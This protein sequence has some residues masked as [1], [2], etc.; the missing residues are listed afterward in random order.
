[1][2]QIKL[3]RFLFFIPAFLVFIAAHA[4]PPKGIKWL[5]DGSGYYANESGEIVKY[6]LP[7]FSKTVLVDRKSLIPEGKTNALGVRNFFMSDDGKTVLLYNNTKKVWR[8]DTRGDYWVLNIETKSLKQ[9]GKS[10]PASSLMF[11]KLSPDGKYA[12]YVSGHNIYTEELATGSMKQL[13]TDGTNKLINGTFDWVYEEEFGCRDGF[14][15]SGD[16][17]SIAYWQ[18]DATKIRNYLMLNTT[19]SIYSFTVPVEYPKVG[20]D[21]SS[22]KV[23]VV[24]IAT[25]QTKWMNVP[26]DAVQ[27]YIPR[28]EWAANSNELIIQQLNRKQ[29]E[30]KVMLLNAKTGEAKTIYE[31]TDKAWI[32]IKSRWNDDDPTGWEWLNNGKNFLWIS[33]K[34]GWRHIY[35]ISRDGKKETL[36]TK[37]DYDM[38]SLE[39]IDEKNGYVYYMASPDNALQQY[40]YRSKLDGSGKAELIS[41]EGMKG[42]HEYKLSP[43]AAYGKHSFSNAATAREE[44]WVKIPSNEV[45]KSGNKKM[46]PPMPVEGTNIEFI[47]V[48][49]DDGVTLDGWKIMPVD[50]D[51]TKKY[52]VVFYVYTEPGATTVTDSYGSAGTFLYN[53]DMAADG[54]IQIS[55]DGRGTPAPKGAAWRKS[56]Y[57]KVGI[58]N[59]QDQAAAAKKILEWKYVDK[60]RIAVWGWSGG[61]STTLN[62]MF[63]YPD[64][65]KTGIAV[66]PVAYRLSYD[67]IYEERYMGLP[68]ENREDYIKASAITHAKGL[69]GNLL[70]VHGTGDDNVHY[71]NTE[72][73]INELVKNNKQFSLMSYPNRT[74]SI[75]EGRGTSLHL[76]TLFTNYLKQHCP[77]GA[78]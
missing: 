19:D 38:I 49:T 9:L 61:G 7:D 10:L 33:E 71:Q 25:A 2:K 40:L 18:I 52:P 76:A 47:K 14:R 26:G 24:D 74:H 44:E 68:Q 31:E 15:W 58:L 60:D 6:Q 70:V 36:A 48:T 55:L 8:Y 32:D 23:G 27:H 77:G 12:A 50:F 35:V 62:L 37:G 39:A 43:N 4:Q 11:A 56:I 17:K 3:C 21:P 13:T 69:K 66:A 65:Y 34:D 46:N 28:M 75:N 72:M 67:N 64:I 57:R 54:Y 22:C 63:Q 29:Q 73:L 78:R 16:S 20:E 42:T 59:I 5:K 51:S 41:S 30:S 53:G 1:M 45:I